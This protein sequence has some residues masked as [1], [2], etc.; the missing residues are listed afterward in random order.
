MCLATQGYLNE[1]QSIWSAI[2]I[3]TPLKTQLDESIGGVRVQLRD[4]ALSSKA[5]TEKKEALKL[6]I[7]SR[8]GVL[9][10]ALAA[11]AAVSNQRELLG[12][13]YLKK[14]DVSL[15]RDAELP[16]RVEVFIALVMGLLTELADYG[17]TETQVT[18][19]DTHIDDFREL[20]GLPRRKMSKA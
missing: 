7:A 10:G 8:T 5:L 19:L 14:S 9:A 3:C 20:V 18:E 12:N 1:N 2:P 15:L 6:L 13:G 17:V 4:A 16:D 11:Y